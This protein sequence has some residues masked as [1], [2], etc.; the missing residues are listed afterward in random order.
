MFTNDD[1]NR[2]AS[3]R[4]KLMAA[5]ERNVHNMKLVDD[6]LFVVCLDDMS[7]N[8]LAECSD[9]LLF[10][11]GSNR[12]HDKFQLVVF[13]NGKAGNVFE[14]SVIDGHTTIGLW[15]FCCSHARDP[16][17]P[18]NFHVDTHM[19]PLVFDWTPELKHDVEE[20]K[21]R[22]HGFSST[23]DNQVLDYSSYGSEM[24]KQMKVSPDAYV[25]MAFQIAYYSLYGHPDST[26]ESANIKKFAGGRTECL[27]SVTSESLHL[28]KVWSDPLSPPASK[29]SAFR[30]AAEKHVRRAADAK[31]GRGVDRHLFG[32][33][34]VA[35]QKRQ[36]VAD[37]E[38]PAF[39]EDPAFSKL[40][41]SVVSTSNVS[42]DAYEL[43]G[44]GPVVGNGLGL[45]YSIKKD[46]L[47]FNV[48]A[49]EKQKAEK[50]ARQ[51]NKTL[52][53][54]RDVLQDKKH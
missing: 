30:S 28:S 44:F 52:D 31:E 13:N 45:A 33:K 4:N 50:F 20:S 53:D 35:L 1:R 34:Q 29:I 42:A 49:F 36:R 3:M 39:F 17:H 12:W 22:F 8:T 26:Y 25:Q 18:H 46:R 23:L 19:E 6:A 2:W 41:T 40:M 24:V 32:L 14:H 27:R 37:Y 48:T 51:L 16:R 38:I 7:P 54:I 43:F 11:D 5:S 47:I 10:G 21:K 9:R 15:N